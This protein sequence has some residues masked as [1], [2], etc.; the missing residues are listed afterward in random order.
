MVE[1]LL[2]HYLLFWYPMEA[3]LTNKANRTIIFPGPHVSIFWKSWLIPVR[4]DREGQNVWCPNKSI[5]KAE[6]WGTEVRKRHV[7]ISQLREDPEVELSTS[8]STDPRS[9]SLHWEQ[10]GRTGNSYSGKLYE[11]QKSQLAATKRK[12]YV[13]SH[14]NEMLCM[15]FS[16]MFLIDVFNTLSHFFKLSSH[17]IA[18]DVYTCKHE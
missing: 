13:V 3:R 10:R 7:T 14:C 12:K 1:N 16:Q 11:I 4:L 8:Q 15:L 6:Q 5:K 17:L 9:T 2:D 18:R